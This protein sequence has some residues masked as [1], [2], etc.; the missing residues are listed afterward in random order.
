MTIMSDARIV[1]AEQK[2]AE[3]NERL[4]C[5]PNPTQRLADAEQDAYDDYADLMDE[6]GMCVVIGC[7]THTTTCVTCPSHT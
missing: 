7:R 1:V 2:W 5:S 3:I 6:L 4:S